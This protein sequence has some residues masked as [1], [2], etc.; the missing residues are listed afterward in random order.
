MKRGAAGF[1]LI[2]MVVT[3]TIVSVL[4][5][6]ALPLAEGVM[7]Y[8]RERELN[9]ALSEIRAALDRYKEAVDSGRVASATPS[10]YPPSIEVLVSGVKDARAS[11]KLIYF[12][13]RIPRDPFCPDGI[14]DAQCWGLRAY[15]T[16]PDAPAPGKDVYDVHSMSEEQGTDGRP[17]RSW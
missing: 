15:D 5:M 14:E 8:T 4:A 12:L 2:E 11:G 3:L 7:Q 6:A 13:R 10:G 1:T 16:P 17:Y 9:K